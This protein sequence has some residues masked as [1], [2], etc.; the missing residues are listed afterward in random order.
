LRVGTSEDV[1]KAV[2]IGRVK[3]SERDQH[4]HCPAVV[5]M[6]Q[7]WGAE[8]DRFGSSIAAGVGGLGG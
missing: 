6:A 5:A 3:S 2:A 8:T 1:D 4:L 7:R